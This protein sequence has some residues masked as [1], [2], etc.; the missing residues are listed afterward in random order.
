MGCSS[1]MTASK[2]RTT[3]V[4]AHRLSTIRTADR[5]VGL[6]EG[7]VKEIGTHDELMEI[8]ETSTW[9][10]HRLNRLKKKKQKKFWTKAK[11]T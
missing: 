5:I 6:S 1:F 2:G 8:G 7:R 3:V 9:F 10:K 4:V 11:N